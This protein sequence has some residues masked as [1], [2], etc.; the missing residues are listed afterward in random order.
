MNKTEFFEEKG[1]FLFDTSM[2]Y[3]K[4]SKYF[5]RDSGE[6]SE[7]FYEIVD[8]TLSGIDGRFVGLDELND[9]NLSLYGSNVDFIF[10]KNNGKQIF[11][12]DFFP[13]GVMFGYTLPKYSFLFG[14]TIRAFRKM[15]RED[16]PYTPNEYNPYGFYDQSADRAKNAF[17]SVSSNIHRSEFLEHGEGCTKYIEKIFD[18]SKKVDFLFAQ[19]NVTDFTVAV[20]SE[21]LH[22]LKRAEKLIMEAPIYQIVVETSELERQNGEP[23]AKTVPNIKAD[24]FSTRKPFPAWKNSPAWERLEPKPER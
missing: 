3:E 16:F 24:F 15:K 17:L 1:L 4:L 23:P 2:N 9:Y 22:E 14:K 7:N 10:M 18:I 19:I 8:R 12:Q 11:A 21:D 5:K 13:R 6:S 20:S